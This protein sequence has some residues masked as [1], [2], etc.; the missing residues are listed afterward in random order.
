[1]KTRKLNKSL[2]KSNSYRRSGVKNLSSPAGLK[3]GEISKK[4]GN[5]AVTL[6]FFE[7]EGLIRPISNPK[8]TH[9]RYHAAVLTDLDFIRVCRNA[10]FSIAETRS[11]IKHWHGFKLPSKTGMSGLKRSIDVIRVQRTGLDVIEKILLA[12]LRDPERDIEE[13]LLDEP[14]IIHQLRRAV[15]VR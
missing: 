3:I 4:S 2:N 14:E 8:S 5:P 15:K 12:R 6:R 7:N 1:M 10:G 11:L 9:R 13:M